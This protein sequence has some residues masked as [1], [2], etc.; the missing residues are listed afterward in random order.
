[1]EPDP[2]IWA[3]TC[4]LIAPPF[5]KQGLTHR[6]LQVILSDLKRKGVRRVQAFPRR[7][8]ELPDEDVWTGPERLYRRA[9]FT[10]ERDDPQKPIYSKRLN[11]EDRDP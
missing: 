1:L 4:L 8:E 5:R 11:R 3:I 10:L 6:F 2:A 7:G 9:G